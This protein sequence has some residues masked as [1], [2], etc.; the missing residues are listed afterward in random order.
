M[1]QEKIQAQDTRITKLKAEVDGVAEKVDDVAGKVDQVTKEILDLKTRGVVSVPT[2]STSVEKFKVPQFDGR[3]S[4][5][6]YRLQFEKVVEVNGWN[7]EQAATALTLGLR[8]QA[9]S[10]LEAVGQG[11]T[12]DRLLEALET[13]YGDKHLEHA[14]RAQL[15]ERKQRHGENLQQ[16]AIEAEKLVRKAYQMQAD[17]NCMLVEAFVDGIRDGEVRAAVRLGHHALLK[18][19]LAH[20]LEVEAVRQDLNTHR[21]REVVAPAQT[22]A[23]RFYGPR[24]YECGERG[25]LRARCPKLNRMEDAQRDDAMINRPVDTSVNREQPEN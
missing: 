20:A 13:R 22:S 19:A 23:R 6:A 24:C 15:K 4:W 10:V 7:N 18:E 21:L 11:A 14:Y 16:W 5:A 1:F 2:T 8:D 17:V 9:L 25:H 12:Y 3:S